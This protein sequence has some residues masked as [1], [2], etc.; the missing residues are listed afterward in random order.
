M[1]KLLPASTL[2][3]F[4][5]TP[6]LK[7]DKASSVETFGPYIHTYKYDEAIRDKV[8]L[9][10][11]YE[12]RDVDQRLA[13]EEKIDKWFDVRTREL[14]D[15][16]KAQLRKRW[17][18]LKKVASS[19]DRIDMIVNDIVFDMSTRDRLM[20]GRGNAMLVSDS[21]YAA[22]RF[23]QCF[24]EKDLKGKC[25]IVTSYQPAPADITGEESGEGPTENLLKYDVYRR[26]LAAHFDELEDVAVHKAE[27]FEKEVKKRFVNEPGQMKLLIVV[28]KLLTGFDAPSA[29]YLYIDKKMQDHGLFQAVCRVNRLDGADKEYG[30]IIDYKDLF[31]SLESAVR[32]YTGEAFDGYRREDVEGLLTDRLERGRERLEEA[33]EA[34]RALCEPVDPPR[35]TAA[36]LRY[37]C[38]DGIGDSEQ[39]SRQLDANERKRLTL[40]RLVAAFLRAW[41]DLANEMIEAGYTESERHSTRNE[42]GHYEKVRQEVKL[43]SGDYVD[44]KM[45]EPAM[46]HLLDAYIKADDVEVLSTFDNKTLVDLL[47]ECS[48]DAL[49]QLPPGIRDNER[50]VAETIE[51]NV[52]RL[53]VDEMSVNPKY[54]EQMSAL[55]DDLIKQR[56]DDK[57]AYEDYLKEVTAL[58]AKVKQGEDGDPR[59][60]SVNTPRRRAIYDNLPPDMGAA[61]RELV[62]LA[63]DR[64]VPRKTDDDWRGNPIK[65]N[66]LLKAVHE[67]LLPYNVNATAIFNVVREQSEY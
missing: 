61:T 39:A 35:D 59:P 24:S 22:C 53:I 6:L 13:S 60:S 17:G 8:V 11:R 65:E 40:Y 64:A 67:S 20:S 46:R 66:Q 47:V 2:I 9:D 41:A 25:A 21:I 27:L 43:S 31:R 63:I 62:T 29:T 28:D 45:F 58:A 52:R 4:R 26:M 36:Y 5:G 49:E 48:G 30:C 44:L 56:H 18:T 32:D 50:T 54:Y 10:V 14:S 38:H 51:N 19:R 23:F 42:V 7:S 33:R 16:A 15:L 55:L 34:V 1:K 3:G 37:F 12:A 57:I